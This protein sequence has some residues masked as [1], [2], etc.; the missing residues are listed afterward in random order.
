MCNSGFK[1]NFL[2]EMV[3]LF[4]M[5]LDIYKIIQKN[6]ISL[7]AHVVLKLQYFP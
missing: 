6:A 4:K 2:N 1:I 3:L 5:F 7:I